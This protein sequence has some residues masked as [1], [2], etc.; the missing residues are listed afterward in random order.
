M[1]N[2]LYSMLVS[3]WPFVRKGCNAGLRM[4]SQ[5]FSRVQCRIRHLGLR[6]LVSVLMSWVLYFRLLNVRD[7][8]Q[9]HPLLNRF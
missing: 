5:L 9:T 8:R 1:G 4:L 6:G 7:L 2:S 3:G